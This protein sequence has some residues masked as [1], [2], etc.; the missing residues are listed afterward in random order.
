MTKSWMQKKPFMAREARVRTDTPDTVTRLCFNEN[1]FGPSPKAAQAMLDAVA[2]IHIYPDYS[3]Q[4][5]KEKIGEKLG[6]TPYHI[7]TGN[8]SSEIINQIGTLFAEPG[9][10]VVFCEP[11]FGA[12]R[13]MADFNGAL[14]RTFPLD[15]DLRFDLAAME[16]AISDKTSVVIVCNPNNPTGT[17]VDADRLEAFIRRIPRDVLVVV[18]EAYI[19]YADDPA[20][21]SMLPL[22]QEG[23][24]NLLILRT[25]SKIYGLAGARVGYGVGHPALIDELMR[26]FFPFNVGS[27]GVAGALA[28]LEDDGHR[29]YIYQGNREGRRYLTEE[30]R[31]LGCIVWDSQ[32]SFVYFDAHMEPKKLQEAVRKYDIMIASYRHSRVSV[33]TME[34]NRRFIAAMEEILSGCSK[35]KC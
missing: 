10:E 27:V 16:Q 22:V 4:Y 26:S 12:Y 18:D 24:E 15:R 29:A 14:C 7:I 5:L 23:L 28:S 1:Q 35:N 20:C 6:L 33:G 13:D 25:F 32:T 19:E 11:S 9:S 17:F 3:T 34:Q 30:L 8:G 2:G 31:R 21:R